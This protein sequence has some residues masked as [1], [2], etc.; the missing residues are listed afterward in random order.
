MQSPQ[1]PMHHARVAVA[2]LAGGMVH[3]KVR[4]EHGSRR[5]H[6]ARAACLGKC[7]AE[8]GLRGDV[9]EGV[10]H[11]RAGVTRVHQH[12]EQRRGELKRCRGNANIHEARRGGGLGIQHICLQLGG[13]DARGVVGAFL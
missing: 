7:A 11:T 4:Q 1:Q 12:H 5:S 10:L 2:T 13:S 8:H 3:D 9:V 6:G